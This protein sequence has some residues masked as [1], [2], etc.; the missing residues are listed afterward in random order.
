M[1]YLTA[2]QAKYPGLDFLISS[3]A[4]TST[5]LD[6]NR[7]NFIETSEGRALG[8]EDSLINHAPFN[9][10]ILW[11][12]SRQAS[13]DVLQRFVD[14]VA[15]INEVDQWPIN[16]MLRVGLMERVLAVPGRTISAS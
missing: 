1:P 8:L 7:N 12:A 14:T 11:F 4:P 9:I 6:F 2:I 3:D 13:V 10:G 5:A 16:L 15:T